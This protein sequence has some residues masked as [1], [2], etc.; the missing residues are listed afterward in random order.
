MKQIIDLSLLKTKEDYDEIIK[1]L[2]DRKE[3]AGFC[4]EKT[5]ILSYFINTLKLTRKNNT[6]DKEDDDVCDTF[7]FTG[8][9]YNHP[10]EIRVIISEEN[11]NYINMYIIFKKK[12]Q[13]NLI[14]IDTIVPHLYFDSFQ[15]LCVN[16]EK[17]LK[18]QIIKQSLYAERIILDYTNMLSY[19]KS[20]NLDIDKLIDG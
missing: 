3:Q 13:G 16:F 14:N 1:L 9:L 11:S 5:D 4:A 10:M 8:N 19:L 17:S 6:F 20:F 18:Q 2:N 15:D 7:Y 12:Y